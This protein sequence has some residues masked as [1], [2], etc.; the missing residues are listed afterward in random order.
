MAGPP[1]CPP[2][3]RT[4]PG[5]SGGRQGER[6][7]SRSVRQ[8]GPSTVAQAYRLGP[9]RMNPYLAELSPRGPRT[10]AEE[11]NGR[12]CFVSFAHKLSSCAR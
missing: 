7:S 9:Y 8:R 6:H 5:L 3:S 11:I 2:S 12:M 10:P 4:N 1:F